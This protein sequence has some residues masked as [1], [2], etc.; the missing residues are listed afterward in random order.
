MLL[1]VTFFYHSFFACQPVLT[2]DHGGVRS[3]SQFLHLARPYSPLFG[4]L[5]LCCCCCY[6]C[7]CRYINYSVRC[8]A[9]LMDLNELIYGTSKKRPRQQESAENQ[10]N[11]PQQP[12][13]RKRAKKG[14]NPKKKSQRNGDEDADQD[15]YGTQVEKVV[16][17]STAAAQTAPEEQQNSSSYP[18]IK[19]RESI[20]ETSVARIETFYQ[21]PEH[22]ASGS[23][24]GTDKIP[25]PSFLYPTVP[26]KPK[27]PPK[28]AFKDNLGSLPRS[29]KVILANPEKYLATPSEVQVRQ[30]KKKRSLEWCRIRLKWQARKLDLR[31]EPDV[32][33]AIAN[34]VEQENLFEKIALEESKEQ[35]TREEPTVS[36]DKATRNPPART[37]DE[38]T[39]DE[40]QNN[41]LS[42]LNMSSQKHRQSQRLEQQEGDENLTGNEDLRPYSELLDYYQLGH[43]APR[44]HHDLNGVNITVVARSLIPKI[45]GRRQ[46]KLPNRPKEPSLY[47]KKVEGFYPSTRGSMLNPNLYFPL[48][49]RTSKWTFENH[50]RFLVALAA[51]HFLG[52]A[53]LSERK[54]NNTESNDDG[55]DLGSA[56]TKNTLE[57]RLLRLLWAPE[58]SKYSQFRLL[59]RQRSEQARDLEC[60]VRHQWKDNGN[61]AWKAAAHLGLTSE[62]Q[63]TGPPGSIGHFLWETPVLKERRRNRDRFCVKEFAAGKLNYSFESDRSKLVR[64]EK[65][66]LPPLTA[67]TNFLPVPGAVPPVPSFPLGPHNIVFGPRDKYHFVNQ[68]SVVSEEI[69]KLTLSSLLSRLATAEVEDGEVAKK[70][71]GGRIRAM[72]EALV[73]IHENRLYKRAEQNGLRIII[74]DLKELPANFFAKSVECYLSIW[75]NGGALLTPIPRPPFPTS[76]EQITSQP[77]SIKSDFQMQAADSYSEDDEMMDNNDSIRDPQSLNDLFNEWKEHKSLHLFSNLHI[78]F[79]LFE[80]SRVLPRSASELLAR[81]LDG[82]R[83]RTPFDV[84]RQLLEFMEEHN[85]IVGDNVS[86]EMNSNAVNVGELEHA[87]HLAAA[88]FVKSVE[89]EVVEADFHSWHLATLAGSLLLCS[90]I[91]IGSSARLYPSFY[92]GRNLVFDEFSAMRRSVS[93]APQQQQQ[94]QEIRL[95][96]PKFQEM[97]VA[98]AKAFKVL[99][100]M[101]A[102]QGGVRSHLAIVSF[103]EWS[104]VIALL[105]GP[106]V[107]PGGPAEKFRQ[108]RSLHYRHAVQWAVKESSSTSI[109]FLQKFA[110]DQDEKVSISACALETDPC[111]FQHWVNLAMNLGPL[112]TAH[113]CDRADCKDCLRLVDGL[114]VNH[115]LQK[116]RSEGNCAWWGVGR[117][118]WWDT[119]LL[120]VPTMAADEVPHSDRRSICHIIQL[121]LRGVLLD[122]SFRSN[123]KAE[124]ND[125]D[126]NKSREWLDA[127]IKASAQQ[128]AAEDGKPP[129]LK[130]RNK[131]VNA[132]LPPTFRQVMNDDYDEPRTTFP[133]RTCTL[134]QELLAVDLNEDEDMMVLCYKLLIRAHLYGLQDPRFE[135]GIIWLAWRAWKQ[136]AADEAGLQSN[137]ISALAYLYRMGLDIVALLHQAFLLTVYPRNSS[138]S[139]PK[140]E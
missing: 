33:N 139:E 102:H 135:Q 123:D 60:F 62:L 47:T 104:Q 125:V 126:S 71:T 11:E 22:V 43:A 29:R 86:V 25:D 51:R 1:Y 90:G 40:E 42:Q 131:C 72:A 28:L 32:G 4:T 111:S 110:R 35:V 31:N 12:P 68:R 116:L 5:W 112:G 105:V 130:V 30:T 97:R 53:G 83:C 45:V 19:T 96:L 66:N 54:I 14:A 58:T 98:V 73:K 64:N 41:I 133:D 114:F 10:Q 74:Q 46:R 122:F 17:S 61:A 113:Q 89:R 106:S 121:H 84:I 69:F 7:Y 27:P 81:S 34:L 119:M 85:M 55:D 77:E 59:L 79:G 57:D 37:E 67:S 140:N 108:I 117:V 137:E 38:D 65:K 48:H 129:S 95:M 99:V 20:L 103:L 52:T 87:L 107:S 118:S 24:S 2:D 76:D 120:S 70:R 75:A 115:D 36:L 18:T 124:G 8:A 101:A 63:Q 80:I 23:A 13:S 50:Q 49:N 88:S 134:A 16:S 15:D 136:S 100:L 3:F 6:C 127:I 91:R 93:A 132:N 78:T 82:S 138:E 94:Q 9:V 128:N 26:P 21:P 92:D 56:N 39:S 109:K 44:T